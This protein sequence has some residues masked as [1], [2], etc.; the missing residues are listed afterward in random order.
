[1]GIYDPGARIMCVVGNNV[2]TRTKDG[3]MT[4]KIWSSDV[5][6]EQGKN[7]DTK[8]PNTMDAY[9][10]QEWIEALRSGEYIRTSYALRRQYRQVHGFCHCVQGVACEI[11]R[12]YL[13]DSRW[14]PNYDVRTDSNIYY[15][16]GASA[17]MPISVVELFKLSGNAS[18]SND[19]WICI[20]EEFRQQHRTLA[21][22]IDETYDGT[23]PHPSVVS[24]SLLN[25]SR[26]RFFDLADLI[27]ATMVGV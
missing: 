12:P 16:E 27:E 10:K 11:A 13:K 5:F 1:M 22:L 15:I 3:V 9:W 6:R 23:S 7:L 19:I 26:W 8:L 4:D 2:D 21:R 24:L 25:D 17:T 20:S 14:I 18:N